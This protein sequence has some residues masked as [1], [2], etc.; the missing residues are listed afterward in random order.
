MFVCVFVLIC[1]SSFVHRFGRAGQPIM[2]WARKTRPRPSLLFVY[3]FI[4]IFK[5]FGKFSSPV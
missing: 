2:C 5:V 1:G 3:L 4:F